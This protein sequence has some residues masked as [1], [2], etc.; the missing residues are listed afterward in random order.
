MIAAIDGA[1]AGLTFTEGYALD[2]EQSAAIT[3]GEVGRFLFLAEATQIRGRLQ[4]RTQRD[5]LAGA[6]ASV[7]P[8]RSC[9]RLA[10]E[11]ATEQKKVLST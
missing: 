1:D 9:L 8:D 2:G 10:T 4:A 3:P 11:T 6:P 5:R 7:E